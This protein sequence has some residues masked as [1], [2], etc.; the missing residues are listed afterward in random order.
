M[1]TSVDLHVPEFFGDTGACRSKPRV[2]VDIENNTIDLTHLGKSVWGS[3]SKYARLFSER[4]NRAL[5]K[6]EIDGPVISVAAARPVIDRLCPEPAG[7]KKQWNKVKKERWHLLED[8]KERLAEQQARQLEEAKKLQTFKEMCT[9]TTTVLREV[10]DQ[11]GTLR[12]LQYRSSVE[13]KDL[14]T[15]LHSANQQFRLSRIY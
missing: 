12:E 1:T 8:V 3:N 11:A 10:Q 13:W 9:R 15:Q 7:A 2:P 6:C 4:L 14:V 5:D